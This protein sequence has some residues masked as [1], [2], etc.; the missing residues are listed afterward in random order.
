MPYVFK[1]T[2]QCRFERSSSQHFLPSLFTIAPTVSSFPPKNMEGVEDGTGLDKQPVTAEQSV[3]LFFF[4]FP[5]SPPFPHTMR[6]RPETHPF[7]KGKV[8]T[9]L[10][11]RVCILRF[12][13][14]T[15][16]RYTHGALKM[17]RSHCF[18]FPWS[19]SP[20]SLYSI[21]LVSPF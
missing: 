16:R 17:V 9:S 19:S 18:T 2:A 6:R 4:P 3:A 12:N 5:R 1:K 21:N 11:S 13:P 15:P 8:W 10:L 20:K 7:K 14:A